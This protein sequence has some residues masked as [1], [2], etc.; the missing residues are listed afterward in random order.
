MYV[1]KI[2]IFLIIFSMFYLS[3]TLLI[4]KRY[5]TVFT[6]IDNIL[7]ST[8][9]LVIGDSHAQTAINPDLMYRCKNIASGAESPFFTYYVIRNIL[10]NNKSIDIIIMSLSPHNITVNQEHM[11]NND[12][13]RNMLLSR[14]MLFLD[15]EGIR[16][17]FTNTGDFYINIMRFK[18]FSPILLLDH[19][20]RT[21]I[22][23]E[24]YEG[25]FLGNYDRRECREWQ[26]DLYSA[27]ID[28]LYKTDNQPSRIS[29]I[30][31]E[32]VNK[33]I[34][35]CKLNE[36]KV[37][38]INTPIYCEHKSR[39]PE[40]ILIAYYNLITQLLEHDNVYFIDY[41]DFIYQ[42]NGFFDDHHIIGP[43]SDT[44]TEKI[45]CFIDSL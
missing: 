14:Y 18:L 11:L 34:N 41:I 19:I 30:M 32:S 8:E 42:Q 43:Y 22:K 38:F 27:N 35:I 23:S 15:L 5:D 44:I 9:I 13:K 20:N 4:K 1:K 7:D 31:A 16:K 28:S 39:I 36:I 2:A 29:D 33:I 17:I 40:E 24:E 25:L 45:Q 6:A 37:I 3:M 10:S 21:N 12:K 26:Y